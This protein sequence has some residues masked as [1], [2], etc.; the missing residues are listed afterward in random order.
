VSATATEAVA[1]AVNGSTRKRIRVPLM[2][3]GI[4]LVLAGATYVWIKGGRFV[5]TDDAYVQ[6]A[7]ATISSNV[8]GQVAEIAVHDNQFVHRGDVLFRLDDNAYR[9]AVD[10]ARAK[11]ANV[12][13]QMSAGRAAYHQQL[14]LISSAEDK[15]DFQQKEF[16]RIEK[17]RK[18]GIATA[19][20]FDATQRDL[21]EAQHDVVS[22]RQ[23]AASVHALIGDEGDREQHPMLLQLK[24]ELERAELNLSYTTIT[25]PYD[26]IVTKVE[27]LQPGDSIVAAAPVFALI[28]THDVWV[29]A[30]FKENQLKYMRAGQPATVE[31]DTYHGRT[32]KAHVASIAPGTGS[33]FSALPPENATGNWVKVV[34][35]LPVRLELDQ[36]EPDL[37]MHAGLSATVEVDT[38]HRRELPWSAA[39][40]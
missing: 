25:A 7:R 24:A 6:A 17:L 9:I 37:P 39:H 8:A 18:A 28:S 20:E 30:N 26:G 23:Q 22:A 34:Q 1:P 13:L 32:L 12:R 3:A 11:L 2:L 16:A 27:Q 35:R 5:S 38:G 36:P 4:V 19:A 29:E 21:V 33:Q 14:V 31:I 10:E 40:R 15:L